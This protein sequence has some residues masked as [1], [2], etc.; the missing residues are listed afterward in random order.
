LANIP[1]AFAHAVKLRRA[2]GALRGSAQGFVDRVFEADPARFERFVAGLRASLPPGTKVYVFGSALVGRSF[3][4][5]G[6]FDREGP[7]TSDVDLVVV[8]PGLRELFLPHAFI[9]LGAATQ[10]LGEAYP[11]LAPRLDG[12][13]RKL[14]AQLGRPLSMT[15]M[16][17]PYRRALELVY[18]LKMLRL[19]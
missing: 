13:R 16:T 7:G 6:P 11:D 5:D 10:P 17:G 14:Q 3:V 4:K 19:V 15:F 1:W 2:H 12:A 18:G 8:G 9:R